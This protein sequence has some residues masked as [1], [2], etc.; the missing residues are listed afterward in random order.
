MCDITRF[1]HHRMDRIRAL[2]SGNEIPPIVTLCGSTRFF[3]LFELAKF[4]FT[5]AGFIVLSIG[6]D[7]KKDGD[8]QFTAEQKHELDWLHKRKIDLSDF[9]YVLNGDVDGHPYIGP[10]TQSEIDYARQIRVRVIKLTDEH[11]GGL[12]FLQLPGKVG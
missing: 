12:E 9:I 8:I 6:C 1:K 4:Q 11:Q 10:S 5:L 7:T 3:P 2:A